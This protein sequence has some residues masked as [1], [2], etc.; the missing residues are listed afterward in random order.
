MA[1]MTSFSRSATRNDIFRHALTVAQ[2]HEA[3]GYVQQLIEK[4][5]DVDY[6]DS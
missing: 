2:D 6:S 3:V 1:A 5:A 4:V